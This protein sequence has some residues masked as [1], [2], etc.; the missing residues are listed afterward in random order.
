MTIN[1]LN[2]SESSISRDLCQVLYGLHDVEQESWFSSYGGPNQLHSEIGE[3]R[4]EIQSI[5]HD[6]NFGS[7]EDG[8]QKYSEFVSKGCHIY[9]ASLNL[10][11]LCLDGRE[12]VK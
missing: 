7:V 11:N 5:L 8:A 4:S 3:C 2:E 1:K 6:L 9:P 12:K 10:L